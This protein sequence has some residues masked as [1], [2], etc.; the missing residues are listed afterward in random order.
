L[1]ILFMLFCPDCLVCFSCSA[2]FVFCH[3]QAFLKLFC[4]TSSVQ[5]VLSW[6]SCPGSPVLSWRSCPGCPVLA[7]LS[8]LS[9][10]GCPLCLSCPGNPVLS[11]CDRF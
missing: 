1:V 2:W 11:F 7:V 8:W 4:L 3:V 10:P 6:L 5:A 9:C